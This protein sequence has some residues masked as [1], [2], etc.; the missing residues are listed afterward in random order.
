VFKKDDLQA[1]GTLGVNFKVNNTDG[2]WIEAF[3]ILAD[4]AMDA[5]LNMTE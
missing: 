3:D 5:N 4:A 1:K 2:E